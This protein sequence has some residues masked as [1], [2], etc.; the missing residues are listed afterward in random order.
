MKH[1][2]NFQ[3]QKTVGLGALS[4]LILDL[5]LLKISLGVVFFS[6]SYLANL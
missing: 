2:V 5:G 1:S 6:F 3:Q 4:G